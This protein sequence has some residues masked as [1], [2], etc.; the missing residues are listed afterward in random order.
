VNCLPEE[1]FPVS[2]TLKVIEGITLSKSGK[3]W[4]AVVLLESFGRKQVAVYLWNKKGDQWKR[5]Q[6]FLIISKDQ[7]TRAKET[8]EKLIPNLR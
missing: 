1:K 7:W 4:S 6:K 3:W 2:E 8:I 5:R